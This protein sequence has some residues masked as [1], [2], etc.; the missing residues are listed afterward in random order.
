MKIIT[1]S[2]PLH[3]DHFSEVTLRR[4]QLYQQFWLAYKSAALRWLP[5]VS[6]LAIQ[7][8]VFSYIRGF[9]QMSTRMLFA[10]TLEAAAQAEFLTTPFWLWGQRTNLCLVLH[11]RKSRSYVYSFRKTRPL[12]RKQPSVQLVSPFT[13]NSTNCAFGLFMEELLVRHL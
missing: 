6:S 8:Y 9:I 13:V 12:V 1:P 2:Y 7:V 11:V 4:L 3:F 5:G 10:A